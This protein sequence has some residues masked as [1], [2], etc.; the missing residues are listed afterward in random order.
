MAHSQNKSHSLLTFISSFVLGLF[1]MVVLLSIF[2]VT[3]SNGEADAASFQLLLNNLLKEDLFKIQILQQLSLF[4][5]PVLFYSIFRRYNFYEINK[6]ESFPNFILILWG[7][8]FAIFAFPVLSF[9][10]QLIINIPWPAEIREMAEAQKLANENVINQ[11]LDI[12]STSEFVLAIVTMGI[13]A[14]FFEELFFRGAIQT[15]LNEKL[16]NPIT[17]I[18]ITGV[19][20]GVFHQNF[21]QFIPITFIGILFGFIFYKTQNLW[22]TIFIHIFYNTSQ[23]VLFYLHKT[24]RIA[25]DIDNSESIPLWLVAISL[26]GGAFSFYKL[27][28]S[29]L[30]TTHE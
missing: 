24:N 18:I 29:K 7:I 1:L 2:L 5:L 20:F 16:K 3:K 9:F 30:N 13:F 21:Y 4:G 11:F 25:F 17:A 15:I 10:E 8:A 27:Y 6:I 28:T 19:T 12:K 26:I 22:I 14:G 23:V